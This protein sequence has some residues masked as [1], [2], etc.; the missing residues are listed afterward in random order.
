MQEAGTEPVADYL[1]LGH[2]GHGIQSYAI[3]YYV[4]RGPLALFLQIGWA[5]LT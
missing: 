5:E 1:L 2:A 3:H 4:V